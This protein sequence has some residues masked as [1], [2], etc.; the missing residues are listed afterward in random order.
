MYNAII[1]EKNDDVIMVLEEIHAGDK[2]TYRY[3]EE[4][5][6]VTSAGEVPI[7]YKIAVHDIPKGRNIIKYGEK[8]GI[9]TEDIRAG[10]HVHVQNLDSEREDL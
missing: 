8:I 3:G 5:R 1:V 10:E 7:Y 9:A 4:D 6:S 2:V